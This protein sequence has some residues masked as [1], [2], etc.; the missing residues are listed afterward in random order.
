MEKKNRLRIICGCLATILLL[1]SVLGCLSDIFQRKESR[2]RFQEFYEQE[3]DF[4]V[5]FL[6]TSHMD[7]AVSPMDLWEQ[8]GIVGYN[9]GTSGCRIATAYWILRNALQYTTPKLVVLDCAYLQDQKTNQNIN[10]M[11]RVFDTMPLSKVKV[12]ALLDLYGWNEEV[13]RFLFPFSLYHNRWDELTEEDFCFVPQY[14]KMGVD[15]ECEVVSA[16]IPDP[17]A[18]TVAPVDNVSTQYLIRIIELCR[19]EEIEVLLTFFPFLA[20]PESQND[21]AYIRELARQYDIRYLDPVQLLEPLDLQTDFRDNDDNNSHVN[22]S[23]TH[24]MSYFLGDYI[25]EHYQIPD[26]RQDP[27]YQAWY[28]YYAQYSEFKLSLLEQAETLEQYLVGIADKN[29]TVMVQITDEKVLEDEMTLD[30][31]RNI[32]I[33]PEDTAKVPESLLSNAAAVKDYALTFSGEEAPALLCNGEVC[34]TWN[35]SAADADLFV[36]VLDRSDRSVLDAAAFSLETR[37]KLQ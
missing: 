7:S 35:S 1:C 29:Y 2:S 32:G 13:L 36:V 15:P 20:S 16:Q 6:G 23:G 31:L 9:L 5:L 10:Y 3:Q 26:R 27:D 24:K 37:S 22:F 8:N 25:M 14:G 19:Q 4:D 21:A 18:D 28:D 30:L 17:I 33:S 11:H 34:H 12:E